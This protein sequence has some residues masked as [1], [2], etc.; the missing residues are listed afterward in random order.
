[1]KVCRGFEGFIRVLYEFEVCADVLSDV[2][3]MY[4]DVIGVLYGFYIVSMGGL[5][6]RDVSGFGRHWSVEFKTLGCCSKSGSRSGVLL[7]SP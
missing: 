7:R 6:F 1:M 4:G 3:E 5:A 2:W